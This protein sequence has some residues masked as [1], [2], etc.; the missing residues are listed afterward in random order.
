MNLA[1]ARLAV[2]AVAALACSPAMAMPANLDLSANTDDGGGRSYAAD[3]SLS[4]T[5]HFTVTAGAGHSQGGDD[6]GDIAGTLWNAGVSLH[7]ERGGVSLR[8]DSFDDSSNYTARTLGA[9]AW[10]GAGDFEIA[11]L[12]RRRDIDVQVTLALPLRTIR[13][14]V[15]FSALG[16]GLEV[17]WTRGRISAYASGLV[18][19]Y[20]DDFDRFI[21][22]SR[23]PQLARRPR[24]E[25]LV[26]SFLT[27]AQ[28]A[29]DRQAGAGIERSFGRQSLALDVS[30][31]HD[32]I[33]DAGSVSV[34]VTWRL[35]RT[36][37][38]DWSVSG[39]VV[40]SDAY[41]DVA[42]IGVGLGIGN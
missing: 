16:A 20:D 21:E 37:R 42:F 34:A 35:A 36:A 10:L 39:G 28:G 25:A 40:D 8:A 15:E 11:L 32:A 24:I 4:P 3:V 23:S 13:R 14:D 27:Q 7:G 22:L 38:L 17:T 31:V 19:D 33:L 1:C 18:Y 29:I 6:T 2:A 5:E 12:G 30:H 9:R 26:G 41:G